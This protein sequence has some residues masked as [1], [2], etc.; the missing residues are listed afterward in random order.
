MKQEIAKHEHERDLRNQLIQDLQEQKKASNDELI[1]AQSRIQEMTIRAGKLRDMEMK[2]NNELE[3]VRSK[4]TTSAVLSSE[5]T[6]L[7]QV[8]V[9]KSEDVQEL[10]RKLI[11]MSSEMT[12]VKKQLT[13]SA[14]ALRQ[15]ENRCHQLEESDHSSRNRIVEA[16]SKV[17]H[18]Q[19]QLKDQ[20]AIIQDLE[21]KIDR[22]TKDREKSDEACKELQVCRQNLQSL[23]A[24][25]EEM[26]RLKSSSD[27]KINMLEENHFA[28]C[29]ALS[30]RVGELETIVRETEKALEHK[31]REFEVHRKITDQKFQQLVQEALRKRDVTTGETQKTSSRDP[32]LHRRSCNSSEPQNYQPEIHLEQEGPGEPMQNKGS[33]KDTNVMKI[34]KKANRMN[35]TVLDIRETSKNRPG[36]LSQRFD[37][38]DLR[39]PGHEDRKVRLDVELEDPGTLDQLNRQP[40][41]IYGRMAPESE[42][43]ISSVS[44]H[45]P[46]A[47]RI[48]RPTHF[49]ISSSPLSDPLSSDGLID[50]APLDQ[51]TASARTTDAQ[52][53]PR[54]E[55]RDVSKG[56]VNSEKSASSPYNVC[57]AKS[58]QIEIR[59]RSQ[60]NTGSKINPYSIEHDILGRSR[61]PSSGVARF[62]P[63]QSGH[64]EPTIVRNTKHEDQ[65]NDTAVL[66]EQNS[67]MDQRPPR[68]TP[69]KRSN[70]DVN[71]HENSSM[72]RHRETGRL[73]SL[74]SLDLSLD[75]QGLQPRSQSPAVVPTPRAQHHRSQQGGSFPV[76]SPVGNRT[77]AKPA[78][79]QPRAS[80]RSSRAKGR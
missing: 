25:N 74:Q 1:T 65:M 80:N 16:E 48:S 53:H 29:C 64:L 62:V 70:P 30:N 21:R 33:S 37:Q 36:A 56:K 44:K 18:A 3:E 7:K 54:I 38:G 28:E 60:A 47:S 19:R 20:D 68:I 79:A 2:L 42:Q 59:P 63:S 73:V 27:L 17:E 66:E 32:Q 67:E 76:Q 23:R 35:T 58:P 14:E 57:R 77:N 10:E 71:S 52:K 22:H 13:M 40:R 11:S 15:K 69:S 4:A 41:D 9:E 72:K 39:F 61:L 78:H 8:I 5:V 46:E 55:D 26:Q 6:R 43:I 50:M 12:K 31:T 34:R 51:I 45:H 24:E 75:E 49:D